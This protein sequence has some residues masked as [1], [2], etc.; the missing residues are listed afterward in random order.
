NF[1]TI[2]GLTAGTLTT[3]AFL[4][5]LIKAWKSKSTSD[6]SLGMFVGLCAGILLWIVYGF[7]IK[8]FPVIIS[9]AVTFILCM[10]I[11]YFKIKY[12]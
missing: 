9:N 10:F 2:L 6:I 3:F 8:S 1:I 12:K 4:P 5:Q 11:L 7:S